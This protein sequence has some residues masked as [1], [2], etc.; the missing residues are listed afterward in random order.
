MLFWGQCRASMW[1]LH[2]EVSCSLEYSL[3]IA[4][5]TIII[6]VVIMRGNDNVTEEMEF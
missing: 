4:F 2:T 6:F 3:R 1:R 5:L